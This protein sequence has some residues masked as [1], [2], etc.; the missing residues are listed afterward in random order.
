MLSLWLGQ[1]A[2]EGLTVLSP[3]LGQTAEEG[4][5]V[6]SQ[7]TE[8]ICQNLCIDR[9]RQCASEMY[10]Q[11]QKIAYYSIA[12]SSCS[13]FILHAFADSQ[14]TSTV[15]IRHVL[16]LHTFDDVY[17]SDRKYTEVLP[18]PF[19]IFRTGPGNEANIHGGSILT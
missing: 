18:G 6:E 10:R 1:T 7:S 11:T 12:C 2:E 3:W 13:C 8:T 15:A 14:L 4:L 5:S 19:S 17:I 16:L 9:L